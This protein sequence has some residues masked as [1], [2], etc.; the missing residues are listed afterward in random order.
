V[1]EFIEQILGEEGPAALGRGGRAGRH[2]AAD[3]PAGAA[4]AP[5]LPSISATRARTCC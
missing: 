5:P 1:K 3:A 2:A 4:Y